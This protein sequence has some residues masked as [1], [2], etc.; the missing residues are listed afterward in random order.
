MKRMIGSFLPL[1]LLML[2]SG[3][4]VALWQNPNLEAWNTP[5]NDPHLHLFQAQPHGDILVVYDEYAERSGTAHT[6]AYWLNENEKLIENRR[7]PHFVHT[8]SVFCLPAVPVFPSPPDRTPVPATYAMADIS[9][10]SFTLY[11]DNDPP[12]SHDLPHY[13]DGKGKV[14]KF[15]LTPA[16]MTVDATLLGAMLGYVCLEGMASGY[17]PSY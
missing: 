4:T 15:F 17:N 10:Q 9:G 13:N 6:R 3:C 7:A 16:A 12:A 5:A 1:L 2:G 11:S 14:E 8:N